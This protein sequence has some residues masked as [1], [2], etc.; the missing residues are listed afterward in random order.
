MTFRSGVKIKLKVFKLKK[1]FDLNIFVGLTNILHIFEMY[2][3]RV[4]HE[5]YIEFVSKPSSPPRHPGDTVTVEA[6]KVLID[7]VPL[8][9]P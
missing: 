2:F 8:I 5:S 7:Q 3:T 9:T 6:M 1:T 4:L